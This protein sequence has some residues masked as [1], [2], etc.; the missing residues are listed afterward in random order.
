MIRI[1]K[2]FNHYQKPI[3]FTNPDVVVCDYNRNTFFCCI[4]KVSIGCRADTKKRN[5]ELLGWKREWWGWWYSILDSIVS[6][7]VSGH[8]PQH[9]T[10]FWTHAEEAVH[11]LKL[12]THT[13]TR[14]YSCWN[15]TRLEMKERNKK[16]KNEK[17]KE[18]KEEMK[19]EREREKR[20][21][22]MDVRMFL[23]LKDTCWWCMSY[24]SMPILPEMHTPKMC[25]DLSQF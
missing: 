3:K 25:F 18:W 17:E 2:H 23:V 13:N 7:N 14:I 5:M 1:S 12:N 20:R 16:I 8:K 11:R 9:I 22:W 4:A 6:F 21:R 24:N 15:H 10:F 19:G